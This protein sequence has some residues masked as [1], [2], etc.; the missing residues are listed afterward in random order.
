MADLQACNKKT[1]K[2]RTPLHFLALNFTSKEVGGKFHGFSRFK[3]ERVKTR[4]VGHKR[5]QKQR[6]VIL[7]ALVWNHQQATK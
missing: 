6:K 3:T 2:T 1:L 4:G 5:A 7:S